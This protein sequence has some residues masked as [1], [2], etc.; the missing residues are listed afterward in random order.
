MTSLED[1][2]SLS[3]AIGVAPSVRIV[4]VSNDVMI[5]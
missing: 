1:R 4:V 3:D 5:Y 2:R